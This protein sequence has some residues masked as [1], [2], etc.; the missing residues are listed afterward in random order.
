MIQNI[1]NYH[2]CLKAAAAKLLQSNL[3]KKKLNNPYDYTCI[4][5]LL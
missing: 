4:R 2:T 1:N 5:E 3:V